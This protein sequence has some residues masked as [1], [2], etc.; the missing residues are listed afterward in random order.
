M[1]SRRVE[2]PEF[3]PGARFRL[4]SGGQGVVMLR[5]WSKSRQKF[6]WWVKLD[7]RAGLRPCWNLPRVAQQLMRVERAA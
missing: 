3:A 5:H 1:Q 4:H 6:G 2:A 7:Q